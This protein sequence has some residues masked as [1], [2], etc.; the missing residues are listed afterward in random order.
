MKITC[1]TNNHFICEVIDT[2]HQGDFDWVKKL[3][4]WQMPEP[5]KGEKSVVCYICGSWFWNRRPFSP[6]LHIQDHGW[7]SNQETIKFIDEILPTYDDP[8]VETKSLSII[9]KIRNFMGI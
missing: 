6:L 8:I 2:I 4:N 9:D 3:G 1:Q 5:K 7:I